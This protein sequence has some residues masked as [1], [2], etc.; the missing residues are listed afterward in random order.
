MIWRSKM[1]FIKEAKNE[2]A[3]ILGYIHY[4]GWIETYTGI[5]NDDYLKERNQEKSAE[6]FRKNN[7]EGLAIIFDGSTPMGIIGYGQNKVDK[8][9]INCGEITALYVLKKYQHQGYG[10]ML[11]EYAINKLKEAG[12]DKVYLWLV[13]KNTNAIKFY[14]HLN[15]RLDGKTKTTCLKTPVDGLRM[16]K[17]SKHKILLTI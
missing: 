14:E 8:D 9:L 5:I 11:M 7:C 2:D 3:N 17:K 16:K 4:Y 15:I 12:D 10:K 6:I 13:A 1:I